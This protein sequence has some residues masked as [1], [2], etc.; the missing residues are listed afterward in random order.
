MK[1]IKKIVYV[2]IIVLIPF[3]IEN[4]YAAG[5]E[6]D[7]GTG[8]TYIGTATARVVETQPTGI[9][10]MNWTASDAANSY[11]TS[12]YKNSVTRVTFNG[13]EYDSYCLDPQLHT[14]IGTLTCNPINNNPAIN[15][16]QEW[17]GEYDHATFQLAFRMLAIFQDITIFDKDTSN[18]RDAITRY[19]E[20]MHGT[21]ETAVANSLAKLQ[22]FN[23]C[24]GDE[25]S[26]KNILASKFLFGNEEMI[27]NALELA[28]KMADLGTFK[29]DSS[30]DRQA[31]LIFSITQ[32]NGHYVVLNVIS[33]VQFE[34]EVQFV[35]KNCEIEQNNFNGRSG[36]LKIKVNDGSCDY[37]IEAYYPTSGPYECTLNN[38]DTQTL[39][40]YVDEE[41]TSKAQ[42]YEGSLSETNCGGQGCCTEAPDIIPGHIEGTVNNCC[43]PTGSEA[44]EYDLDEL[45]CY[46]EDLKVEYYRKKCDIDY[47]KQENAGLNDYCELYCTERVSVDLPGPITAVSG[48][49]FK[50]SPN[51]KGHTT[52]PYIQG[53]RRCRVRIKYDEWEKDYGA[54]VDL[55]VQYFNKIQELRAQEKMYEKA[56][57][58]KH[59]VRDYIKGYAD[60]S[61]DVKDG[62]NPDGSQKY[63]KITDRAETQGRYFVYNRWTFAIRSVN[64]Y[65]I[66]IDAAKRENYTAYKILSDG[67]RTATHP[68]YSYYNVAQYKGALDNLKKEAGTLC[69]QKLQNCARNTA[70]KTDRDELE[71]EKV[72]YKHED[73][74]EE[75]DNI[76]AEIESAVTYYNLASKSAKTKEEQIDVCNDYFIEYKG[77]KAEENYKFDAK[78]AFSYSQTYLDDFGN[79]QQDIISVGWEE[80]PGCII[81][82]P[83]FGDDEDIRDP[84]YS[85]VYSPVG[86]PKEYENV[87]DMAPVNSPDD[88]PLLKDGNAYK[89]YRDKP[90]DAGKKFTHDAKY[91]AVCEWKEKDN[92]LYTLVPNGSTAESTSEINYTQHDRQYRVYLS[93]LDGTYETFWNLS[94]L[95]TDGR[96]DDY[97]KKHGTT[98]AG[99]SAKDV[100][101]FTCKLHVEY[102]IVLTGYCNGVTNGIDD[103][104]PYK[105]GYD[106]FNFKVVDPS[107]LFPSGT[108]KDGKEFA[109]NWVGT[110]E[111]RET[112]GAIEETGKNDETYAIDN[113]TYA[114]ELSPTD[115]RHIKA[116]NETRIA[117][118]GYSDFELVCQET[119]KTVS[120]PENE[121][122][123]RKCHSTFL[124]NLA[125][126]NVRYNGT[127]HEVNGWANS[128]ETLGQ[129]RNGNNW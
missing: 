65:Q 28:N 72:E 42:V 118:G 80:T 19:A 34:E 110:E 79:L 63:K 124:E 43:G 117:E 17:I 120:T 29:Y 32:E 66:K 26:D 106:L 44:H 46:D 112:L 101:I 6:D 98:C 119:C 49:Y 96:F 52:S 75:L 83:F 40:I 39:I 90:Y 125:A 129:V 99:E 2:L 25:C 51:P 76:V 70:V 4:V 33:T 93:T 11:V 85:E 61:C 86:S 59:L 88:I 14:P 121:V 113:L 127:D 9:Y 48:R 1:S 50:L 108:V 69:T 91:T 94:G 116:Y 21:N 37:Q 104:S 20:I 114:F 74:G 109:H 81:E 24:L 100:A 71:A 47:Y 64:Y 84:K 62:L 123:C 54:Q 102:E 45:F 27:N 7:R 56:E 22:S 107:N 36:T 73:V 60:C 12:E 82:G 41:S 128:R 16:M 38:P 122:G 13:V 58:T 35:C 78:N 103:C 126:G 105:E 23:V 115:M 95:G 87:E 89:D 57:P 111:G 31:K 67:S 3:F 77:K 5:K 92:T 68:Q 30:E 18:I 10:Y 97:F 15:Q 53:V 8:T 55:Q